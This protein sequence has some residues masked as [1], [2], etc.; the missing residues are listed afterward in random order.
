MD[1]SDLDLKGARILIVDDVPAN[2]DALCRALEAAGYEVLVAA[3]GPQALDITTRALPDLILLD[4]RMPGMDGFETCRRL[5]KVGMTRDIPVLFVT[6][7]DD[8]ADLVQGFEAGGADY[9]VKPVRKEEVLI[10]VRTHLERARLALALAEKNAQLKRA[11]R[12]LQEEITRR[13]T[14]CPTGFP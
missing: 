2:Q 8:T 7:S 5:K 3:S 13:Q 12:K 9:L 1:R 4:V 6:A 11:N 14:L 10:R